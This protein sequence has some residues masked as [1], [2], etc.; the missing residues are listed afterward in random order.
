M[1]GSLS[2]LKGRLTFII[3][4]GPSFFLSFPAATDTI[5][6]YSRDVLINSLD[7][8]TAPTRDVEL[9]LLEGWVIH[10]DSTII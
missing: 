7:A 10:A 3:A 4:E 5:I 2:A 9:M 8:S 1:Q 6:N